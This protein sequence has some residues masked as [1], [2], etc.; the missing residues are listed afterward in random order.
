MYTYFYLQNFSV[1]SKKNNINLVEAKKGEPVNILVMGVDVGTLGDSSKDNAQRTD[2]IILLNYNPVNK[3]INI[4]SIPRDTL[5]YM[6]GKKR[7]I[8]E[9]HFFGALSGPGNG[10]RYLTSE[11]EKLLDINVNYY[12]KVN[13]N[14]FIELINAIGGVDMKINN[15]MKYDDG[16]QNLHINFKKGEI[17]HLD[18]QKAMEFFRWRKNNVFDPKNSGDIG[19]IENQQLFIGKVIEKI[20]SPSIITKLPR[21]MQ[22]IPKYAETNMP[23]SDILSYGFTFANTDSS[24]IKTSMIK[25][26]SKYID[27]ISYFV[28]EEKKNLELYKIL[29]PVGSITGPGKIGDLDK[30]SLNLQVLNCTP[31]TG[32]AANY[33]TTISEKGYKKAETGN[34][35]KLQKSK[36]V[37][38]GV[39]SKYDSIIKSEFG[40]NNIERVSEKKGNFDITIMLGEDYK[41]K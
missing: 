19:R 3:A 4:I 16:T 32:L 35:E 2:T 36:I 27:K 13:Y 37:T 41:A 28:Y 22:V 33:A 25:G 15:T 23:P 9:A 12:G 1:T 5:I 17:V 34:G 39:D 38:Y 24:N 11:V 21:I 8:N 40:I 7:K 26:T 30:S 29:H 14:G 31:R 10:V 20:K 18:G 6:D